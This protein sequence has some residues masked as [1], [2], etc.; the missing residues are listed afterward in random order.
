M[1]WKTWKTHRKPN[2]LPWKIPMLF[3]KCHQN[4]RSVLQSS[5]RHIMNVSKKN[6]KLS[7]LIRAFHQLIFLDFGAGV[8]VFCVFHVFFFFREMLFWRFFSRSFRMI[9]VLDSLKHWNRSF[10]STAG[11]L[12]GCRPPMSQQRCGGGACPGRS[13]T[14]SDRT[15]PQS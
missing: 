14:L 11:P 10:G 15:R 12:V 6:S 9:F 4:N 13:E 2:E 1:G 3:L 8:K 5:I 7:L